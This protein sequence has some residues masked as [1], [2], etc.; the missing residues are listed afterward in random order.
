MKK[1]ISLTVDSMDKYL[2]FRH[3]LGVSKILG[4]MPFVAG[5]LEV[6]TEKAIHGLLLKLR[7]FIMAS[8]PLEKPVIIKEPS[9]WWEM[10][11]RD[12]FPVAMLRRWP[13][14]YTET[15]WI[16]PYNVYTCPHANIKWPGG[17]HLEFL[18]RNE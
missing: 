15:K 17:E 13:V 7:T 14:K 2:I 5:H 1:Q 11:K 16:V 8:R 12:W 4:D 18:G 9:T 3:E 6:E 10:F